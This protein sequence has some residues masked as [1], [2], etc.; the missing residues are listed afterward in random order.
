MNKLHAQHVDV[1]I[2]QE[3]LLSLVFDDCKFN[4]LQ[5]DDAIT[6]VCCFFVCVLCMLLCCCIVVCCVVLISI[7]C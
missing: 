7:L 2:T 6:Y 1:S 3:R 5:A 4:E